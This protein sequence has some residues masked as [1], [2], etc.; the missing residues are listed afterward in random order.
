MNSCSPLAGVLTITLGRYVNAPPKKIM[1][2]V[3][4]RLAHQPFM[5]CVYVEEHTTQAD[6]NY[7]Q[8]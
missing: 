3:I 7:C 8:R 1:T 5:S 4:I 2:V 6:D